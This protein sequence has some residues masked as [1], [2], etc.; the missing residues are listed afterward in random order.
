MATHREI[1]YWNIRR[2]MEG[3]LDRVERVCCRFCTLHDDDRKAYVT[4]C[5]VQQV[6]I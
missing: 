1:C 3:K 6:I 4:V 2:T 5:P